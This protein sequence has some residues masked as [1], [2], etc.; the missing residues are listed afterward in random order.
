VYKRVCER[1]KIK[2]HEVFVLGDININFLK[3]NDDNYTSDYLDMLL[4][5]SFMPL[6]TKATQDNKLYLH[7]N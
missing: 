6:I 5:L 1:L 2:G 3:Y 7:P 4:D